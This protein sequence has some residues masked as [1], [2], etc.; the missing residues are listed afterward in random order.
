MAASPASPL[1][2][3][4]PGR[5]HQVRVF[6]LGGDHQVGDVVVGGQGG[7]ALTVI[8]DKV[9]G[10]LAQLV[11]LQHDVSA[12]RLAQCC[13]TV[14]IPADDLVVQQIPG[15]GDVRYGCQI[16][17]SPHLKFQQLPR[18]VVRYDDQIVT[19]HDAK[20]ANLDDDRPHWFQGFGC[21]I[22]RS[23]DEQAQL[24]AAEQAKKEIPELNQLIEA[25]NML[26]LKQWLNENIHQFGR[27]YTADELCRKVTGESL[28]VNVF[29]DYI[30]EKLGRVYGW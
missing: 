28:N 26:P 20:V 11:H 18:C 21:W 12:P 4:R 15:A 25:G 2:L 17:S 10:S 30:D 27:L 22:S 23:E 5:P 1:P 19:D 8:L 16:G 14:V 24:A 9:L 29:M 3:W 7:L 6:L 13:Q